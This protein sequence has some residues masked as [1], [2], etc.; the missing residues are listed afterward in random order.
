MSHCSWYHHII[1]GM[2]IFMIYLQNQTFQPNTSRSEQRHIWYQSWNYVIIGVTLYHRGIDMILWRWLTIEEVEKVLNEFHS[3]ELADICLVML[4]RRRSYVLVTFGLLSFATTSSSSRSVMGASYMI[5][6]SLHHLLCCILLSLLVPL[7]NGVLTLWH[8]T[9]TR[10]GSM[11]ISFS[12]LTTLLSVLRKWLHSTTWAKW[13][14]I[15][16]LI[17]LL[18]GLEFRKK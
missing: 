7:R 15:F 8:V 18:L 13:L 4:L 9:L 11:V 17:M 1:L 2:D 6:R 16:S 10:L 5:I 14:H 12:L 3:E